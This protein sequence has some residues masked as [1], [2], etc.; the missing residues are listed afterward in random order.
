MVEENQSE[1]FICDTKLGWI[2][3]KTG[4]KDSCI[5]LIYLNKFHSCFLLNTVN[6]K[7]KM[8]TG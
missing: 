6:K 7:K 8:V 1:V 3:K 5:N 2:L 4:V